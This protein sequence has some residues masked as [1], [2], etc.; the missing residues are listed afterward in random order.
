LAK[1]DSMDCLPRAVY[2]EFM[3]VFDAQKLESYV[4][5]LVEKM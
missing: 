5:Y 1:K 3:N 4:I 2:R